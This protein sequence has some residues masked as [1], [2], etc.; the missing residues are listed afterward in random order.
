MASA[1]SDPAADIGGLYDTV[2]YGGGAQVRLSLA[3]VR[4]AAAALGFAPSVGPVLDV[5]DIG[6]GAGA[7]LLLAA[8]ESSGRMVGIDAS[9]VACAEARARGAELGERWQILHGDAALLDPPILDPGVLGQFDVIYVIGTLYILPAA[10]RG[11][12]LAGLGACLKPGGVVVM[13]YY[14]GMV[15]LARTRLGRMLFAQN[16][17]AWPVGWQLATA[18]A[19]L[20]AIADAVPEAGVARELVLSTLS[21]MAASTDTVLFHE[22]L[23]PEFETLATAEIEAALAGGGVAFLNYLPPAPVSDGTA[24]RAAAQAVDAWDF[25]TGGGYRVALFGFGAAVAAGGVRHPG[26]V[27]TSTLQAA[28][29]ED[30]VACF[31]D[32]E[33]GLVF[34]AADP[35]AQAAVECLVAAPRD[36]AE[37][38]AA[39]RNWLGLRALAVPEGFEATLEALL[40]L[41]WR[42]TAAYPALRE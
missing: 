22:A 17:P 1:V 40:L 5:L 6:C 13:N 35:V 33:H 41:L 19:N 34:R 32:A 9:A 28:A 14:A 27:W 18:R 37:L 25:A 31:A 8:Q 11:R 15:G 10:A 20:Q 7:Q 23:G 4:G 36:W 26:L 30:G 39:T 38:G 29:A 16:D 21:S 2:P 12:L 24:S 3:R 42:V